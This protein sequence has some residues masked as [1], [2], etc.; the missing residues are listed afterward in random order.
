MVHE[1]SQG[2]ITRDTQEQ[3]WHM[4]SL[5]QLSLEPVGMQTLAVL[6]ILTVLT[7]MA[8]AAQLDLLSSTH[9]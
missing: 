4:F 9:L 3:H 6:C 7:G 8:A 2:I 5:L 1:T